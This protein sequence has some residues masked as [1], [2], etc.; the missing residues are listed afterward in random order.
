MNQRFFFHPIDVWLFRDGKP[1]SAGG[2]HRAESIFPP[3]PTVVQGAIRSKELALKNID[4]TDKDAIRN[5]VGGPSDFK[6]LR[7]KGPYLA[8]Q[9]GA[10]KVTR[11]FPQ[12]AD[13]ISCDV[14]KHIIRPLSKPERPSPGLK[15]NCPTS[16]LLGLDEPLTKGESGLWLSEER[17][18]DYLDGKE[19]IGI[20]SNQLFEREN[21]FGVGIDSSQMTSIEGLIYEVNYI[22][23]CKNV[24]LAIEM[25]GYL[26]W[27]DRDLILFGGENR[28]AEF[29]RC[30][31]S[32]DFSIPEIFP[33]Q[34]KIYFLTPTYF[35][36]GWIPGNWEKFF[37][38]KVELVSAA[39]NRS[40]II[41]GFDMT[42]SSNKAGMNRPSRRFVPAGSVYYFECERPVS[43]R[44]DLIQNAIT[45]FAPEIG[46]GQF[47]VK[48]W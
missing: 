40:E 8:Q 14:S 26:N 43:L 33:R 39:L 20:P 38:G 11:F 13:A 48:E 7:L 28:A 4:L 36:P 46:F 47:I 22:R 17:L 6:A 25:S 24:G 16:K 23:P 21:R 31:F 45:D 10:D 9:N 1:F 3:F 37:N 29:S 34:F 27:P 35:E 15:T 32:I 42:Q 18:L 19:V 44:P 2:D 30:E 5:A 12:P 41:G